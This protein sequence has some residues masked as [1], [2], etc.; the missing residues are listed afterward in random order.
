MKKTLALLLALCMMLAAV[1]VMAEEDV[2]GTW[3][4]VMLGM[5]AGTF[6]LRADGTCT[7]ELAMDDPTNVEGTWTLDGE[8]VSITVEGNSLP[9]TYDGTSLQLDAE[10]IAALGLDSSLGAGMDMSMI[11]SMIQL[12]REPG[13]ITV[14]EF[15][16]YQ[17]SSTLPEGK[18]EED[19]QAIQMEMMAAVMSM[20]GSLD[21]GSSSDPSAD[22][23]APELTVVE[24]NF[25]VREGFSQPEGVYLAKVQNDNTDPIYIS[26]VSLILQ[27][28]DG[29][30]IGKGEFLSNSGSRYLEPGEATFLCITADVNDGAE[31]A[32]HAANLTCSPI[33]Y[34][35]ADLSMEVSDA[36]LRVE[37]G[38]STNYYTAATVTN[39]TDAPLSRL[40]VVS[41][42][43]S[44]DGKLLDLTTS[45]L[46]QN[47]LAAG[48]TITLVDSLDSRAV[49]YCTENNLTPDQVEAF[50]WVDTY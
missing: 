32:D 46:Y 29:N 5:T 17:D 3:Y 2:S 34:Q 23:P 50:A 16:D 25:Y 28:K 27:D 39:T 48:S 22:G 19:M 40:N 1:P 8:K 14:K 11:S 24:D 12:S 45:G 43:R 26:E 41:A 47:E 38:Y 37:E 10:G 13:K 35:T 30:E 4:L 7:L 49:T 20:M 9:L 15:S 36:Q 6:D 21:T 42:V 33:T 44:A 31:V 18:T